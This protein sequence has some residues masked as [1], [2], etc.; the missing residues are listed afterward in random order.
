MKL[1]IAIVIIIIQIVKSE[2]FYAPKYKQISQFTQLTV[3]LMTMLICG[4]RLLRNMYKLHRVEFEK[5]AKSL[6]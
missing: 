2:V 6:L 3:L 5:S 4:I 1:V